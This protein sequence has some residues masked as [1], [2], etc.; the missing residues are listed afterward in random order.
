MLPSRTL[1]IDYGTNEE[2]FGIEEEVPPSFEINQWREGARG[3]GMQLAAVGV[4][5]GEVG[6]NNESS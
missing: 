6:G 2:I 5:A 1:S 4:R 3:G